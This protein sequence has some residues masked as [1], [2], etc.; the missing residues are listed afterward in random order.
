MALQ[1]FDANGNGLIPNNWETYGGSTLISENHP[2]N[3]E[4]WLRSSYGPS[5][6]IY[7]GAENIDYDEQFITELHWYSW[8]LVP[9]GNFSHLIGSSLLGFFEFTPAPPTAIN[10]ASARTSIDSSEGII[11]ILL[12]FSMVVLTAIIILRQ[13]SLKTN[14]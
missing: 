14:L 1:A 13:R 12:A 9:N 7:S 10:L 2:S 4:P 11:L 5:Q 3:G 8:A 6:N